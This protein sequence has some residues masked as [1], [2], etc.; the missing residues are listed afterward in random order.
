MKII[1]E[2]GKRDPIKIAEWKDIK[3]LLREEIRKNKEFYEELASM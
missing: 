2:K 3:H 1:H